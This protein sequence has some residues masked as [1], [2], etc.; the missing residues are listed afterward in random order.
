MKITSSLEINKAVS[1]RKLLSEGALTMPSDAKTLILTNTPEE[2]TRVMQFIKSSSEIHMRMGMNNIFFGPVSNPPLNNNFSLVVYYS[3][4][5]KIE[6]LFCQITL[7]LNNY[8]YRNMGSVT[9]LNVMHFHLM[10]TPEDYS[11]SR[12]QLFMKAVSQLQA[13]RL[14]NKMIEIHNSEVIQGGKD[15]QLKIKLSQLVNAS[16]LQTVGIYR[17]LRYCQGEEIVTVGQALPYTVKL[18]I[19]DKTCANPKVKALTELVGSEIEFSTVQADACCTA[20]ECSE[21]GLLSHLK[22][23]QGA[24]TINFEIDEETITVQLGKALL[25]DA[26][27]L[28]KTVYKKM[29][30]DNMTECRL[31]QFAFL[32]F[33]IGSSNTAIAFNKNLRSKN[34][35]ALLKNYALAEES[36]IKQLFPENALNEVLDDVKGS[37]AELQE[38]EYYF[39]QVLHESD[40]YFSNELEMCRDQAGSSAREFIRIQLVRTILDLPGCFKPRGIITS[41]FSATDYRCIDFESLLFHADAALSFFLARKQVDN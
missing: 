28:I 30:A 20:L 33:R 37:D 9:K 40:H 31:Q 36:K 26:E 34:M 8:L 18:L 12:L 25:D 24:G 29:L 22:A 4:P 10:A 7:L 2:A 32:V 5:K 17:V 19:V 15:P 39:R 1:L 11:R 41:Q 13:E 21:V 6:Q 3:M 14:L 23:L 38:A 16:T 27:N 35:T